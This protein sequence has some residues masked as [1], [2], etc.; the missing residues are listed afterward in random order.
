[1]RKKLIC[2][3]L[4]LALCLSLAG[5]GGVSYGVNPVITLVS[6]EYSMAFRNGDSL[7]YYVTAALE[8][9]SAE[10][11]ITELSRKWLGSNMVS[12]PKKAGALSA[13]Q[14]PEPRIFI[15]G[16]DENSFP[17]A[18]GD[19]GNYW[20]FDV[21]L[22]TKLCQKLGW[23]LQ[24]HV[25]EKEDVYIELYSGNIDCAWGGLAL[26][27]KEISNGSYTIYGP[28][29]KND[30][31]IA[32]RDGSN[33]WN[34]LQLSGKRMAM[35]TTQEAMDALQSAGRVVNRLGQITRLAGGTTECFSYL[36]AGKCDLI[37]TDSTAIAYY[38]SH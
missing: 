12:F 17:F 9:L 28:Y 20:G 27:E 5:C 26:P 31:V 34:S 14:P 7:Y 30:I 19:N 38:N 10:G 4:L 22:A 37:L 13:Y 29:V 24:V 25:V 1:M 11:A 36:Y 32:S 18:Y 8:E 16:V 21:E 2:L 33:I 3:L 35:C 15:I 6:Q 23:T